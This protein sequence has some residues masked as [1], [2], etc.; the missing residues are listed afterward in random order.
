[1]SG[2]TR[3]AIGVGLVATVG[4]LLG[5]RGILEPLA[6]AVVEVARFLVSFPE[7]FLWV[8]VVIMGAL[9]VLPPIARGSLRPRKRESKRSYLARWEDL[10]ACIELAPRS[11]RIRESLARRLSQL[12]AS[13]IAFG[14]GS[15]PESAP[16]EA[17]EEGRTW[18]FS[19]SGKMSSEAF[20]RALE[21]AIAEVR[22]LI[23]GG[24]VP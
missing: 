2:R 17:E 24:D 1:M 11:S 23:H 18:G 16:E 14:R 5:G 6:R 15:S 3:T 8:L 9:A 13:A 7:R 22:G 4:I 10:A 21:Q 12:A 19:P 20:H